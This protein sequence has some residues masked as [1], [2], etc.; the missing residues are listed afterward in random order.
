MGKRKRPW[1]M[2]KDPENHLKM[3]SEKKRVKQKERAERNRQFREKQNE[4]FEEGSGG[5]EEEKTVAF[6]ER[7]NYGVVAV[8]ENDRRTEEDEQ[9]E[10]EKKEHTREK[11]A[12][13]YDEFEAR[14]E[15]M[16][17]MKLTRPPG[18]KKSNLK[19]QVGGGGKG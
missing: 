16:R 19:E 10:E 4:C 14:K 8:D 11:G 9:H 3:E 6:D 13:S 12:A 18:K 1:L 2:D 17:Q 15:L 7:T 5:K